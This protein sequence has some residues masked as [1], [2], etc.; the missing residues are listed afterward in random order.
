MVLYTHQNRKINICSR[1]NL[2]VIAFE[3]RCRRIYAHATATNIFFKYIYMIYHIVLYTRVKCLGYKFR[4]LYDKP[5][6]PERVRLK[7]VREYI[8]VVYVPTKSPAM[9]ACAARSSNI[10]IVAY[11]PANIIFIKFSLQSTHTSHTQ[12]LA[13]E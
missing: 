10:R 11:A 9:S 8:R 13:N 12:Q 1:Q 6:R 5:L 3:C 4:I 7:I 2:H